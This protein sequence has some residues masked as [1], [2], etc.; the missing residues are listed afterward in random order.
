[1]SFIVIIIMVIIRKK[2]IK[3]SVCLLIINTN[4]KKKKK[5]RKFQFEM[6]ISL[7]IYS[8]TII[9]ITMKEI[10]SIYLSIMMF[11]VKKKR[12]SMFVD[13]GRN[14]CCCCCWNSEFMITHTCD[15]SSGG[16][17]VCVKQNKKTEWILQV[18]NHYDLIKDWI[19]ESF[20]GYGVCVC[21]W[22]VS[23]SAKTYH[24]FSKIQIPE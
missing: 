13:K 18:I 9:K 12:Y 24:S 11:Y 22:F 4:K 10:Q 7:K 3:F 8:I 17:N 23:K 16:I 15:G 1:M 20:H 14:F 2:W 5:R 21:V 6:S 19:Y